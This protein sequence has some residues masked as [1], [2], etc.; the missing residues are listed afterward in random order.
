MNYL[1]DVTNF[2]FAEDEPEKSDI[3]FVAGNAFPQSSEKA[4][5][6]YLKGYAPYVMPS[7]RFSIR[8]GYF[9]GC[10]DK[11]DKYSGKYETEFEFMKD[12][13]KKNGV[14]ESVILKED[15]A[16]YTYQNAL[17]SKANLDK[18]GFKVKNAILCCKTFH[19]R[20]CLM[21]YQYVFPGV[22]FFLCPAE[23][24]ITRENW[25][26]TAEGMSAVFSEI[27]RIGEQFKTVLMSNKG[28]EAK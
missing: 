11:K 5:E 25:H 6:L 9:I 24:D 18:I 17:F 28:A 20:R 13:L 4:A 12:V 16:Q 3:I 1:D 15:M 7:G 10:A 26:K 14:P 23:G 21:Y 22:R 19:A 8:D 27:Q 2:I